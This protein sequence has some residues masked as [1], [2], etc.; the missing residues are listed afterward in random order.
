LLA[1]CL[2]AL[3]AAPG[4][5]ADCYAPLLEN[6]RWSCT[7]ELSTGGEAAYC[8]NV[9]GTA[10][11]GAARTFD[12]VTTG[13]YPRTCT[14]GAKGKGPRAR[15]NTASSYLCLDAGTD[16]A[17]IGTITRK[18]LAGQIYNVSADVRGTFSCVPDPACVV[19][20]P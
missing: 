16:T 1:A 7:V 19:P 2:A 12:M 18:K 5:A 9:T 14:C 17:E 4:R 13:P 3:A 20:V 15:F 11:E 10:G 6:D 8:L